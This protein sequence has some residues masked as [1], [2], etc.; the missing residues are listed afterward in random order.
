MKNDETCPGLICKLV[1]PANK[2]GWFACLWSF[3]ACFWRKTPQKIFSP[4]SCKKV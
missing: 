3:C 2:D 1:T 4:F